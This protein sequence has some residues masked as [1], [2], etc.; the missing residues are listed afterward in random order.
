MEGLKSKGISDGT[1][2]VKFGI[3]LLPNFTLS[4]LSLFWIVSGWLPTKKIR[5]VRLDAD[6]RSPH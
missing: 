4:A 6:G 2:S 3:F 5:A 1:K